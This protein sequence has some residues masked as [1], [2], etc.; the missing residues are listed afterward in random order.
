VQ[1][2]GKEELQQKNLFGVSECKMYLQ[3]NGEYLVVQVD[4][5]TK[6]KKS[7]YTRFELFSFN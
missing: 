4:R 6:T 7:T 5:Y 2:P 3:N 1:I